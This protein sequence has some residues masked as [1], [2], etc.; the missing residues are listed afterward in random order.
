[1]QLA[2]WILPLVFVVTLAVLGC[3]AEGSRLVGTRDGGTG[4]PDTG[5]VLP[6]TD[7]CDNGLDDNGDGFID[8]GCVC[9]EGERQGCWPGPVSRRG[10]GIC[11]DGF[12]VCGP[13]G[14]FL[15]WGQ[16]EGAALPQPEIM[17]NRLDEDCDG[18]DPG[19]P[20]CAANEFGENCGGGMDDDCDGLIDCDD[21]DCSTYEIC[22]SMCVPNEFGEL[23]TD[24]LDNDCDMLVDCLDADCAGEPACA[25][26]PGPDPGCRPEFPFL[27]EIRCGD[28]ADN[29]CDRRIDCDDPDCRHPGSCGCATRET[30]CSDGA[31]ADCDGSTD[32]ADLDCQQCTA[33]SFRWCDDPTY[34]HWGKQMCGSDGRWGTCVETTDRPSGCSGTLYSTSCCISAG[35]CCQNYPTD[36]TSVGDCSTTVTCLP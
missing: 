14:E 15:A 5:M 24:R 23:C 27:A 21:P 17:G 8:E 7:F 33:G 26:D 20:E 35:E 22:W 28:G 6:S 16:C 29:D 13:Y 34:C 36:D 4:G 19:S 1:M 12:Q 32:C 2:R 11:H 3:S 10:I 25:P 30:A 9:V 18:G 31:D